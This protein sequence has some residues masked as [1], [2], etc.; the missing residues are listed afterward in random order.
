MANTTWFSVNTLIDVTKPTITMVS[1]L[2]QTYSVNYVWANASLSEAGSWCGYSLD[3][4]A[5]TTM[6]SLNST[7]WY[8]NVTSLTSAQHSMKFHCN[9]TAGNMNETSTRWFNVS[10]TVLDTTKP[11]ITMVS[12][13]NQTYNVNYVYAN[14]SVSESASLCQYSL[15]GAANATLTSLNAT[16]WYKNVTALSSAQ[17]SIKFYCNDTS[18]NMNETSTR[19]F[20]ISAPA[21]DITKPTITIVSPLNSSYYVN[22]AYANVTV[23]ESA[24]WCGYS[25]DGAANTT[26]TSLNASYWY[27]NLTALANGQHSAKFYCNDTAGNMNETSLRVFTVW[28]LPWT[29]DIWE[30]DA[31]KPQPV[32]FTNGLNS[33]DNSWGV[34]NA[35]DGWD[36]IDD[37]YT[38]GGACAHF[39]GNKY[40]NSEDPT[41]ATVVSSVNTSNYL[42]IEIGDYSG[43]ASSGTNN[44]GAYGVEFVVTPDM[45][46][47]LQNASSNATL[48]FG[49]LFDNV[50]FD[51][52]DD[53]WVK[54]RFGNSTT[55]TYLGSQTGGGN[56]DANKE[57][58]YQQAPSDTSGSYST[59]VKSLITSSGDYYLELGAWVRN[60]GNNERGLF[61]FDSVN[62]VIY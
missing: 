58:L 17:H 15:D 14:A 46:A 25:L 9:D 12:P 41:L 5:N 43:C 1:P 39:N 60:W 18:G 35:S 48:S 28:A 19:W 47:R 34:A 6:T 23:D 52:N 53:I 57:I 61:Q 33:T 10:T 51:N 20:N 21:A 31:D 42:E 4:A 55:M 36:W 2:N 11:T 56:D 37:T 30:L 27:K 3:G 59:D 54:A 44:S 45:Y 38:S 29:I 32:D 26:L 8:Y 7:Y 40:V 22:W 50:G 49:W 24:S 62:L 16:Y 13:L